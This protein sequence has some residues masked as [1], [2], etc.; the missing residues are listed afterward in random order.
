[1]VIGGSGWTGS[2]LVSQLVKLAQT[3]NSDMRVHSVDIRLPPS[4]LKKL[5]EGETSFELCDITDKES[6]MEL[7][8]RLNPRTIFHTASIV[9][10]RQYPSPSIQKV[11]VDGTHN[12]LEALS[13]ESLRKYS[14]FLV[15]TSSIDVVSTRQGAKG[16]NESTPTPTAPSNHYK[17]TKIIAEKAVVA[18]NG[19]HGLYTCAVRPGHIFGPAD[20]LLPLSRHPIALGPA[21]ATMSFVY[22]ENVARA[23]LL[24]ALALIRETKRIDKGE[25]GEHEG[26][27]LAGTALFVNDFDTNFTDMYRTLGGHP[28]VLLRVHVW[29]AYTVV[30]LAEVLE[31]IFFHLFGVQ[32]IGHPVTGIT[33][34]MLEATG[35][36]TSSAER[37]GRVI[38][39]WGGGESAEGS[40]C[41]DGMSSNGLVGR[42]E[43]MRRTQV[44]VQSGELPVE[45]YEAKAINL[46]HYMDMHK[47]V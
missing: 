25:G 33:H 29:L 27:V 26:H 37:A 36:L 4:T 11:N 7:I 15:Y 41:K 2:F 39:Y 17:R 10:L 13:Q 1:M 31:T 23:H 14:R 9:D 20:L 5:H 28:P 24:A 46:S 21:S 32:I 42:Q 12:I 35:Y 43:A 34:A 44:F 3:P 38:G 22:V 16:A 19:L 40:L 45:C 6:T 30:L 18:K 47:N 8:A